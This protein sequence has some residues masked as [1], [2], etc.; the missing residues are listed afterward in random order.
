MAEEKSKI[1]NDIE[2]P[3]PI[4]HVPSQMGEILKGEHTTHD[5]VF[6]EVTEDGPNYRNVSLLESVILMSNN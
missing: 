2:A 6:G 5:A 4:I 1:T 3:E